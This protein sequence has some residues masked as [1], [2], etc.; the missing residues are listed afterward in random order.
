MCPAPGVAGV[1]AC[2]PSDR[3][4]LV[5]HCLRFADGLGCAASLHGRLCIC[6]SP[7]V[8]HLFRSFA[9]F[10]IRL[11]LLLLSVKNSL[12]ALD[13]SSSS[14][15]ASIFSEPWAFLIPLPLSCRAGVFG[16]R[17]INLSFLDVP[18]HCV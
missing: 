14:D 8:R 5:A 1:P 2:G 12:Y 6:A 7:L 11:Y 10:L 18:L 3:C 15:S 16:V 17:L 13:D 4:A 9:H